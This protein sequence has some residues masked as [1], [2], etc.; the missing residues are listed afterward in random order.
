MQ[1]DSTKESLVDDWVV[2]RFFP[3]DSL[4]RI[5]LKHDDLVIVIFG[6][7]P[8]E[9]HDLFLN[10]VWISVISFYKAHEFLVLEADE[11][12]RHVLC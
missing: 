1:S 8:D 12:L 3:V 7:V 5:Y 2:E 11:L 4:P 9:N 10:G 6:L